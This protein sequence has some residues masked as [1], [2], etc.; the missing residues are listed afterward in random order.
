MQ[1]PLD[2]D[3]VAKLKGTNEWLEAEF[4][5]AAEAVDESVRP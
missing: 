3:V 5:K 1:S 2:H 4:D